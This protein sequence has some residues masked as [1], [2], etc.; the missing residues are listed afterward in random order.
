MA[1]ARESLD[2]ELLLY[3]VTP[4]DVKA[5]WAI[6][7]LSI[8]TYKNFKVCHMISIYFLFI[9]WNAICPLHLLCPNVGGSG[10]V[11]IDFYYIAC[12]TILWLP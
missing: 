1:C 5:A 8:E 6:I 3:K 10:Y 4:V 7:R 9:L 12:A 2:L 11:R